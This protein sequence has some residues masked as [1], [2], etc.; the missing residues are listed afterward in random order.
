[1]L[2]RALVS[3]ITPCYNGAEF[4]DGYFRSILAQT[5]P[6]LEVIFI[7]DG[8]TD[9]TAQIADSYRVAFSNRSISF[10]Y[11]YQPNQ[12][13]AAALNQGLAIFRG[14]YFIWPDSDDLLEPDSIEKR[15]AFLDAHPEHGFVRSNADYFDYDTGKH[16]FRAS[17][18]ENR[19][20]TDI[21]LDLIL[22]KTY[23]CCG[24]YMVR[25]SAFLEIY[26]N[27][28]IQ[29]SSAGQN[30][31]LLIP[32]SGRYTCGYIDEDLYHVA[33]RAGSHSRPNASYGQA[34]ERQQHLKEILL[35][36]IAVSGRT[37]R[38]Y[39]KIVNHKY[40]GVF[41]RI[42]VTYKNHTDA[43][44]YYRQLRINKVLTV[45]QR[46]LYL[47]TYAP[48]CGKLYELLLRAKGKIQRTIRNLHH[49]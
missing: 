9:A 46:R 28:Q 16:L 2:E 19:F 24:C 7:D 33:M 1:M 38:D 48:I 8:S 27:R 21:F 18:L 13:Q 30:W 29:V 31:Q 10:T 36:S 23:C 5:Y 4:L 14:E 39:E 12:G 32:L 3:I 25:R 45:D 41:F 20:D 37:D 11:I 44:A 49:E 43:Q 47:N 22:E 6:H 17:N 26:P 35:S 42:A 40:L 15:A 34:L